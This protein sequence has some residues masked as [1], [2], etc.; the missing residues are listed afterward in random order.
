MNIFE[1]SQRANISVRKLRQLQHLGAL[2]PS[3]SLDK[4]KDNLAAMASYLR[5][6]QPLTVEMLVTLQRDARLLSRLPEAGKAQFKALGKVSENAMPASAMVDIRGAAI[7]DPDCLGRFAEWM[8][9][10][11]P[12]HGCSYHYLGVR[13]MLNCPADDWKATYRLLARAILNARA[14]PAMSGWSTRDGKTTRFCP[15]AGVND[16][17]GFDL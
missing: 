1:L 14:L 6:G 12:R 15:P 9:R 16:S 2:H 3:I 11:I 8:K 13:A 10:T 5:K 4:P 7:S 17:L